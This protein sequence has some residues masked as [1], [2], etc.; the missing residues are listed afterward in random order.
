MLKDELEK[1]SSTIESYLKKSNGV[2][3]V[4][5]DQNLKILDCNIGFMRLF[6]P[7]NNPTGTQLND[8]LEFDGKDIRCDEE[9]KISCSHKTGLT[10]VNN[11]YFIQTDDGYLLI[12]ER[13]LLAE[14][15]ALEQIGS[16]NNDLIN[17]QRESVKKNYQ[18]EKLQRELDKRVA[19]LVAT[20]ARVKQLEGIIPICMYC[21]K[22]RDDQQSWHQLETYISLHSEALFSHGMCPACEEEQMKIIENMKNR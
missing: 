10:A 12:C 16:I 5:L 17:L 11:C 14:S 3:I 4:Q 2:G 21:K 15:R 18:L 8:Y 6:N 7:R 9:L 13:L 19:E 1:Y 22:I 20:L